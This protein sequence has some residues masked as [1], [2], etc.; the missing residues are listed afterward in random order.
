MSIISRTGGESK[1]GEKMEKIDYLRVI[2]LSLGIS[3]IVSSVLGMWQSKRMFRY[4]DSVQNILEKRIKR[5]ADRVSSP[6]RSR[7]SKEDPSVQETKDR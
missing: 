3:L 4:I 7:R 5:L 6:A 1:G 2:L